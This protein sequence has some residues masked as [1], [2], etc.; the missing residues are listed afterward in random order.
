MQQILLT[1]GKQVQNSF[2][3]A[4]KQAAETLSAQ[5]GFLRISRFLFGGGAL[6]I[7][8][9]IYNVVFL[10]LLAVYKS[11][12]PPSLTFWFVSRVLRFE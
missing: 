9:L 4:D 8:I 12:L 6:V 3:D 10:I 5:K 7:L 11:Q 1:S 2:K